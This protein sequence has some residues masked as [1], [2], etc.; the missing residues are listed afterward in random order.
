MK[1]ISAFVLIFV[2]LLSSFQVFA[3]NAEDTGEAGKANVKTLVVLGDSLSTGYALDGY[4]PNLFNTQLPSYANIVALSLSLVY[5]DSYFNYAS[6]GET[7]KGLLESLDVG[8]IEEK[9][10]LENIKKADTVVISI[11]G[12]DLMNFLLPEIGKL[13]GLESGTSASELISALAKIDGKGLDGFAKSA[14]SFCK[15]HN[16]ELSELYANYSQNLA[17][18]VKKIRELAPGAQIFALNIYDPLLDM[19]NYEAVKVLEQNIVSTVVSQMNEALDGVAERNDLHTLDVAKEF[20]GRRDACTNIAKLDV[21]PNLQ[22]HSIIADAL[23]AEIDRVYDALG[24]TPTF[25]EPKYIWI[26]LAA[27]V[28]IVALSVPIVTLVV[29]KTSK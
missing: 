5:G 19:P 9:P 1:K 20:L 3:V 2:I 16:K 25:G 23:L 26:A 18:S 17:D 12:N 13:L 21:H 11:G 8:D 14:K 15:D 7:S 10:L 24:E 22:G 4:D 29:K 27:A 6:D 28:A